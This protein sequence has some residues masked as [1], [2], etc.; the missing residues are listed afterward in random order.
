MNFEQLLEGATKGPWHHSEILDDGR[1]GIITDDSTIVV[2]VN[3]N[4]QKEDAEYIAR[5]SPAVMREVWAALKEAKRYCAENNLS[6]PSVDRALALLD[7]Q[8]REE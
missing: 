8:Q 7:G 5:L 4:L 3:R 6:S 2:G 1:L